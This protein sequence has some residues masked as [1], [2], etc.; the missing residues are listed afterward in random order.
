MAGSGAP[1]G[2]GRGRRAALLVAL[3]APL[4]VGTAPAAAAP[5]DVDSLVGKV[6]VAGSSR[7]RVVSVVVAGEPVPLVGSAVE[8]IARLHSVQVEVLGER[9]GKDFTVAEYRILDVGGGARPVVGTLVPAAG[10][11]GLQ[12]GDGAPIPLSIAPRTLR[13]L[14]PKT[15]AK[16]W[17]Y[18]KSLVSGQLQVVRYGILREAATSLPPQEPQP[19]AHDD[20][21]DAASADG[22]D[23][24]EQAP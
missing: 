5:P 4:W 2:G 24:D 19:G 15:G 1:R 21:A 18:G 10:G 3:V 7:H 9:A 23:G 16:V 12:T 22:E 20:D 8:E 13:R 17:I 11:L 14:E 6:R